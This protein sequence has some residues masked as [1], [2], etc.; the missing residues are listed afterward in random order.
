MTRVGMFL[1]L[2]TARLSR[3]LPVAFSLNVV[4]FEASPFA[5]LY[6]AVVE[7]HVCVVLCCFFFSSEGDLE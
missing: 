5:L 3:C 6:N 4:H 2:P 7:I 1:A